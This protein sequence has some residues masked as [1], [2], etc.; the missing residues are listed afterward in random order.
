MSKTLPQP[1]AEAIVHRQLEAYNARDIEAFMAEW[2]T[3][4]FHYQFPDTLLARGSTEIRARHVA[5]FKEAGLHGRLISRASVDNLVVDHEV[6]SRMFREGPGEVDVIAIYEIKAD[7]I[8][9]AWFKHGTPRIKVAI[10][11]T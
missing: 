9:K 11:A 6:V 2:D 4:A 10:A 1:D 3:D 7:K 5:R 8:A